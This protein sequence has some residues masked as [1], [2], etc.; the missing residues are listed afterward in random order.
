MRNTF[1]LSPYCDTQYLASDSTMAY[2]KYYLID[3]GLPCQYIN[4][5]RYDPDYNHV[6]EVLRASAD[7]IVGITGYSRERF[8]AYR[9]IN[10]IRQDVPRA[11]IIVGGHHF[12]YLAEETLRRL[13]A[14]DIVVRGEG[15]VTFKKI[16]DVLNG[17][18][19]LRNVAGISFRSDG[20][21][22]H[23]PDAPVVKEIDQ[24]RS[25]DPSDLTNHRAY[26]FSTKVD[27]GHKYFG[28]R[29]TRGC[30][31]SCVFCSVG[32]QQVRFRSV[33]RVLDEIEEK[34]AAFG[35]RNVAFSDS[36]LTI[37]KKYVR[38][39][40]EGILSR[41]LDIRWNC[42]SRVDIDLDLMRLMR[43]SGLVSV[44]LALESGSDRVL[45]T[46]KKQIDTR[47]YEAFVKSAR[48]LGIKCW[49]F[50]MVSLP[51]ETL[52]DAHTT[53]DLIERTAPYV[54]D[55]GYQVTRILPDA[56]LYPMAQARNVMPAGFNWFDEYTVPPSPILKTEAYGT[57]PIYREAMSEEDIALLI[58]RYKKLKARHFS[59]AGGLFKALK[60]QLT[61]S[62]LR[63]MTL[64][65]FFRKAVNATRMLPG[66]ILNASKDR[67]FDETR[68]F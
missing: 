19:N 58:S 8:H 65:E 16:C 26:V 9:L 17:G 1:L 67:S 2:I 33:E 28:V 48:E 45:K 6:I 47:K 11:S 54:Y 55:V 59:Y 42:Y 46:I 5:Q 31:F 49:V 51:D 4:C 63:K 23:T 12:G 3:N 41:K 32:A 43:E 44:E 7:P 18:E 52:A 66:V 14:V 21:V 62:R 29:A 15:E 13:P 68:Q 57:I 38:A 56:A 30:P 64:S 25:Y 10:R 24:F 40:C 22:I 39:L 37:N 60:T 34:I 35:V 53:L 50:T 20:D 36:S 27:P 61:P